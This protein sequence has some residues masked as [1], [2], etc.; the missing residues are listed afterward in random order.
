MIRVIEDSAGARRNRLTVLGGNSAAYNAVLSV[1]FGEPIEDIVT[2]AEAKAWCYI[3]GTDHDSII[4][5]LI[6]AARE[7]CEAY[8]NL[9]L[10][11]RTVTAVIKND[12]GGLVLPY[13]PVIGSVTSVKDA[14]NNDVADYSFSAPNVSGE[15][16]VVYTAGYAD[17]AMPSLLKTAWLNQILYLFENRDKGGLSPIAKNILKPFRLVS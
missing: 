13:G 16:T 5:M 1:T 9:T 2:L 15:L 7:A 11:R 8:V 10:G 14:D 17:G 3:D 4:T 12:L 6:P